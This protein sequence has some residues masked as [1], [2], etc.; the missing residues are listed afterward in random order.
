VCVTVYTPKIISYTNT[1]LTEEHKSINLS[2]YLSIYNPS[3]WIDVYVTLA[4][5]M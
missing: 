3:I 5:S 1:Q 4:V 2:V